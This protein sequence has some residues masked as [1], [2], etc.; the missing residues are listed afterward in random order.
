MKA[1]LIWKDCSI[2]EKMQDGFWV[3]CPNSELEEK[4]LP[5]L[6]GKQSTQFLERKKH[7]LSTEWAT[8]NPG[9][10]V[11]PNS[12]YFMIS[13]DGKEVQPTDPF[14][15]YSSQWYVNP[16]ETIDIINIDSINDLESC[17]R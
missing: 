15:P 16:L 12:Y 3:Q 6:S 11:E 2:F 13:R 4:I 9:L 14:F 5:Y 17:P 10:L 8:A 1:V 7:F